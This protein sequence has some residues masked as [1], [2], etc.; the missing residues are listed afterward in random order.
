VT[1]LSEDIQRI[2]GKLASFK[3][4]SM[5]PFT[6]M[7]TDLVNSVVTLYDKVKE[8]VMKFYNVCK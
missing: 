8:D 6:K 4:D 1:N 5:P 3:L 2:M 7:V